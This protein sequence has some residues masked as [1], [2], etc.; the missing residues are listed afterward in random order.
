MIK[1][2]L[3][4]SLLLLSLFSFAQESTSSPYSFYGLGE[5]KFKGTIENKSMGGLGILPD[6]IHMNLQNPASLAHLKLTTF[7]VGGTYNNTSLET[8]SE[9]ENAKRTSFDYLAMA[10]PIG[11]IGVSLGLSPFSS[12]GYKVQKI[13]ATANKISTYTGIGSVNNAFLGLGYQINSKFSVG[14]DLGYNFGLIETNSV[15]ST[16]LPY[17]SRELNT[18]EIRGFNFTTGLIYKSKIKKLDFVNSITFS[19]STN[20]SL[21]NERNVATVIFQANGGEIVRDSESVSVA[22]SNIKLPSRFSFGS[23]IGKEK[24]WFV[25]FESTFTQASNFTNRFSTITNASFEDAS[26]ISI[27]GYYVPD[28][29]NYSNYLKK[30]TYRAGLRYEN[31]GLVINNQSIKDKAITLGIGLPVGG[32]GNFSSINLGF[33]LGKK[34]T[35]NAN[36]IQ[37]NYFNIS[38]GLSF[39]DR[40]FVKRKFN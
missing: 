39:S 15:I 35:T 33:E 40:W 3:L 28:Y 14:L 24:N 29:N 11:K 10:F 34:G 19:P 12:V 25:G 2:I 8:A 13:D 23:G 38:I 5:N 1:K 6:S 31:T 17:S 26:K 18:S 27:G 21:D 30:V 7:T 16:G 9:S 22:K 37:E 36:L 32:N 4:S 20:L